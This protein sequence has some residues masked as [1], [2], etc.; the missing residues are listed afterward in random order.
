MREPNRLYSFYAELCEIHRN[1]FPDW[2]FGQ[3]ISNVLGWYTAKYKRDIFF[4]EEDEML[5]IFKDYVKENG[6]DKG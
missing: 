2:R 3:M 5:Q 1:S 6:F 4:P